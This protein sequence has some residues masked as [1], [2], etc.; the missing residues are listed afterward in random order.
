MEAIQDEVDRDNL[1]TA[2]H[3]LRF[4]NGRRYE[5]RILPVVQAAAEGLDSLQ[6][7]AGIV[8]TCSRNSPLK[9][10]LALNLLIGI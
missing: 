8:F 3:F 5:K 1:R 7:S 9:L 4:Q 2:R 6:S 10:F